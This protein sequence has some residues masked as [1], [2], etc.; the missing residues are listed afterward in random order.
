MPHESTV[1]HTSGSEPVRDGLLAT[2]SRTL[3]DESAPPINGEA[4]TGVTSPTMNGKR[5]KMQSQVP[6]RFAETPVKLTHHHDEG[7]SDEDSNE[8]T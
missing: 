5:P 3:F 2:R 7:S 1:H 8:P 6:H 4:T